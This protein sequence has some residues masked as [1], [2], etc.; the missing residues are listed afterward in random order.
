MSKDL[1]EDACRVVTK[2]ENL[3][4][5]G[6]DENGSAYAVYTFL[7]LALNYDCFAKDCVVIDNVSSVPFKS[8]DVTEI[9]S[10]AVRPQNY[11]NYT[12]N[13]KGTDFMKR[14]RM[15]GGEDV[16]FLPIYS[17]DYEPSVYRL[18]RVYAR[19]VPSAYIH[20][21]A[22]LFPYE[23]YYAEHSCWYGKLNSNIDKNGDCREDSKSG[24]NY[25]LCLSAR[26]NSAEYDIMVKKAAQRIENSVIVEKL[27]GGKRNVVCI[28][29]EDGIDTCCCDAC[30][31]LWYKYG[32]TSVAAEILFFND[33]AEDVERWMNSEDGASYK[34]DLQ[35]VSLAYGQTECAPVVKNAASGK[36]EGISGLTARSNVGVL[37]AMISLADYSQELTSPTNV[38]A[39]ENL[40][41]W[42]DFTDGKV[43]YFTYDCN[44]GGYIYPYDSFKFYT[45]STF[46]SLAENG[47]AYFYIN[48]Q[49]NQSGVMTAWGGL[50]Q[51][52]EAKLLWDCNSDDKALTEKYFNAV[53]D[54]YAPEMKSLFN[55]MHAVADAV[56]RSKGIGSVKYSLG[57]ML[58]SRAYDSR[59]AA[60]TDVSKVKYIKLPNGSYVNFTDE[61]KRLSVG[62]TNFSVKDLD[63]D[64]SV[65]SAWLG[66]FEAIISQMNNNSRYSVE[67]KAVLTQRVWTEWLTPA[68]IILDNYDTFKARGYISAAEYTALA[69]KLYSV[70]VS[71]GIRKYNEALDMSDYIADIKAHSDYVG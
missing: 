14:M 40:N 26:G 38:A 41:G 35:F 19:E 30:F 28:S 37:L 20:N 65:V 67:E 25:N 23:K 59:Y 42:R 1:S 5:Y 58:Y 52:L 46:K 63:W 57:P 54:A 10:F 11:G 34:T 47:N 16:P 9:P 66:R 44:F 60:C 71:T 64:Y 15:C 32:K 17:E 51:Y 21:M 43:Y 24:D 6:E 12:D 61:M 62:T 45:R 22:Q 7:R 70:Y 4:L 8:Y 49:Y 3:F 39:R 36:Y 55:E 69:D 68:C 31:N 27:I 18:A 2:D 53:Y 29:R 50:K 48:A 13:G 33:V 56:Y